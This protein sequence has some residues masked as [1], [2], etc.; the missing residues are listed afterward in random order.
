M[1]YAVLDACMLASG[2]QVFYSRAG[3]MIADGVSMSRYV[4]GGRSLKHLLRVTEVKAAEFP[5]II[6][7]KLASMTRRFVFATDEWVRMLR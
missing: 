7:A 6:A 1:W 5:L 3:L 2:V 4:L